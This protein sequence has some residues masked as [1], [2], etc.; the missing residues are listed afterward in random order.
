[1]LRSLGGA[2]LSERGLRQ[3]LAAILAA[4]V[5]G[6]S[7]L[8]AAD[9]RGTVA[10]LGAARKVFRTQIEAEHGRVI[11]MAG[12][13]VL[14]VFD[15]ATGA[16]SA[17]LAIQ[18]V[19]NSTA[20]SVPEN[21]RMHFRMGVHLGDV[22]EK[23]DGTIYGDGV[24]IAARL[25][26]LAQPGG[27]TI[28][29]S[30]YNAVRGKISASFVDQGEQKVK[31][32]PHAVRAFAVRAVGAATPMGT[33][34]A[35]VIDLS[36]PDKPSIAVLPFANLSGDP[37]QEYFTDGVT[38]DII[39]ELSRFRS[40]FV[41]ARHSTFTYKGNAI[42]VRIVAKELGVRY[43][44][45]GSIRRSGN[46]IRVSGQLI[47]AVSGNHIWADRFDR[48][49]EDVFAVQEEI[50]RSIVTSIA[51][52]IEASEIS[53]IR[54]VRPGNLGAYEIA[55][56]AW[57]NAER[58]ND[59]NDVHLRDDAIRLANEALALDAHSG[60]ALNAL[61]F[62]HFQR[63]YYNTAASAAIARNAAIDAAA[64]AIGIDPVDHLP[65]QLRG[66]VLTYSGQPDEGLAELRRAHE[67]NPN[68]ARLLAA[69][70]FAEAIGGNPE[71][72]LEHTSNSLRLSPRDP[73][74]YGIL[75]YLGWVHFCARNY[76]DG[77]RAAQ[78]SVAHMLDYPPASL[79][80]AANLVGLGALD[81][82]R[83]EISLLRQ[84]APQF[85]DAR[86]AGQ[87]MISHPQFRDRLTVFLRIAAGLEDPN[88]ANAL[89]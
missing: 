25:E 58:S 7:R 88:K 77:A 28:S 42:D 48:L 68:D 40:L 47:D 23:G 89:R 64:R 15:T 60:T 14:A 78:A 72:G 56:R 53:K 87:S 79:C 10:A 6:Y 44:L 39:T 51:P 46:R 27:L 71:A 11:D 66:M 4:D 20:A 24:N 8:M 21:R 85:L 31:N 52:Q 9:E 34:P 1:L 12:D 65:H 5:A 2:A 80:L 62:A 69:L 26:G 61:A 45:E 3:R 50:T 22:I 84:T 43:V 41:I 13:S 35:G 54:S 49:L 83:R 67:L 81:E 74:R 76:S 70:G 32:I 30:V 17:A 18:K 19:V 29:D 57:W 63:L 36:L 86:L 33:R 16:V 59:K 37:D 73:W 55:L 82:A 75:N 38:E